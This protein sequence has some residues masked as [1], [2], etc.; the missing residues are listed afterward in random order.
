MKNHDPHPSRDILR[1]HGLLVPQLPDIAVPPP[2]SRSV[3]GAIDADPLRLRFVGSKFYWVLGSEAVEV[4]LHLGISQPREIGVTLDE[5]EP[6]APT[7]C[8]MAIYSSFEELELYD[9]HLG[10]RYL[11]GILQEEPELLA[12]VAHRQFEQIGAFASVDLF[13]ESNAPISKIRSFSGFLCQRIGDGA[14]PS[15]VSFGLADAIEDALSLFVGNRLI[16]GSAE[17]AA[18]ECEIELRISPYVTLLPQGNETVI[19]GPRGAS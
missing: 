19:R 1:R 3:R 7:A 5:S 9:L 14:V 4:S 6:G 11:Q 13:W 15:Y 18:L 10:L 17:V 12:L 2:V 16:P 8:R